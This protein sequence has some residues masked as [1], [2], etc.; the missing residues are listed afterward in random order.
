MVRLS[1]TTPL[2]VGE[3]D[4]EAR[5]AICGGLSWL[6]VSLNLAR[7]RSGENPISEPA[8]PCAVHVL[9]SQ[10]DRQI[11]YHTRALSHEVFPNSRGEGCW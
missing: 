8:S 1:A 5:A 9:P 10:E 2:A 6:G 3:N 7:N 11:A 4:V